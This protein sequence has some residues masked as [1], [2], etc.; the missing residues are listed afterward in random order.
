MTRPEFTLAPR[1]TLDRATGHTSCGASCTDAD[2]PFNHACP[3]TNL[4]NHGALSGI[5]RS[6]R[7]PRAWQSAPVRGREACIRLQAM[8]LAK[9]G[10]TPRIAGL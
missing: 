5:A 6:T 8:R 3:M 4:T 1:S 7:R 9:Y 2:D 10:L